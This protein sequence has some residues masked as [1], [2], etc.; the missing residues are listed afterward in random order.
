VP[1]ELPA[2]IR[3]SMP[4]PSAVVPTRSAVLTLLIGLTSL[5][6][7]ATTSPWLVPPY[8]A[9]MGWLLLVPARRIHD[10]E[11]S[12]TEGATRQPPVA[13]EFPPSA[14]DPDEDE[15]PTVEPAP[16]PKKPRRKAKAKAK[17]SPAA[18]PTVATFVQVAPGKFVRVEVVVPL[19]VPP[20]ADEPTEPT[21]TDAD[22]VAEEPAEQ[23][24]PDADPVAIDSAP[25]ESV[26]E[27]I[28]VIEPP[29]LT[30]EPEPESSPLAAVWGV[31]SRSL[32][33]LI[34]PDPIEDHG[35]DE[36]PCESRLVATGEPARSGFGR[37]PHGRSIHFRLRRDPRP[38]ARRGNG[39]VGASPRVVLHRA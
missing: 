33:I 20:P 36:P 1:H 23:A 12:T 3:E 34:E 27:E 28:A 4:R 38:K 35:P 6:V 26:V 11:P 22:S 5:A 8:L 19:D 21:T 7:G 18:L 30:E 24:S 9:A 14:P 2:A 16:K 31:E 17:D 32:P 10:A 37:P 29:P 25:V 13:A 39:R 15:S